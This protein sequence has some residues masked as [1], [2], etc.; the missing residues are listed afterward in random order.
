MVSSLLSPTAEILSAHSTASRP[1]LFLWDFPTA[2][3]MSSPHFF[4]MIV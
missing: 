3:L 4:D 2:V 1:C